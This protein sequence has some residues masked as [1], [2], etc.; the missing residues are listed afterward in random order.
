LNAVNYALFFRLLTYDMATA[1]HSI[2]V[3]NMAAFLCKVMKLS[4]DETEIIYHAALF[5]DTGK[6]YIPVEVLRAP[7]SLTD[8][9]VKI[10]QKHPEYGE[11]IATEYGLP[12]QVCQ[13]IRQHHERID[14]TGYPDGIKGEDLPLGVRIIAVCDVLQAMLQKRSYKEAFSKQKCK[15]M[16]M[17][18]AGILDWNIITVALIFWDEIIEAAMA[19]QLNLL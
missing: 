9:E 19:Q 5:H 14:G 16:L 13:Y 8:E 7:R 11:E 3:A 4:A 6:L 17:K 1:S 15:T 2:G 10:M 18:S 12:T